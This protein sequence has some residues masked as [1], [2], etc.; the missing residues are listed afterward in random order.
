MRELEE[1]LSHRWITKS[2]EKELYY[3]IRDSLGEIRKFA[4]EK[5]GCQVLE[6]S[7]MVKLE[8]IP[9]IPESFMGTI[10]EQI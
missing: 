9:A 3:K 7:L 2:G 5:M 6:N 4:T 8:K 1:L 10:N